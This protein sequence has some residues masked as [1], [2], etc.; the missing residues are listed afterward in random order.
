MTD[1][2]SRA[3]L[4]RLQ[5]ALE[6]LKTDTARSEQTSELRKLLDSSVADLDDDRALTE[7]IA[8]HG[9]VILPV[10]A[11]IDSAQPTGAATVNERAY[12]SGTEK[13]VRAAPRAQL[14]PRTAARVGLLV[15]SP[16]LRGDGAPNDA[17]W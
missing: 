11:N 9:T 2:Q 14:R 13:A 10:E 1:T 4:D 7:A 12:A 3:G 15:L 17:P 8:L 6:L 5:A 16:S